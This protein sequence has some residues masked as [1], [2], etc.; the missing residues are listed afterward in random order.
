MEE[1]LQ[2]TPFENFVDLYQGKTSLVILLSPIFHFEKKRI[3]LDLVRILRLN[4]SIVVPKLFE[5]TS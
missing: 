1:V 4:L 3:L 5:M 2:G